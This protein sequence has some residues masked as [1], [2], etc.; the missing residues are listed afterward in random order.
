MIREQKAAPALVLDA[1]QEGI[2]VDRVF[3]R[4]GRRDLW[5]FFP[6]LADEGPILVSSQPLH[7]FH[8]RAP[9]FF[10]TKAS[11]R[12]SQAKLAFDRLVGGFGCGFGCVT[13][14]YVECLRGATTILSRMMS[15]M[16]SACL[17]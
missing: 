6:T 11:K 14:W 10:P 2:R 16:A 3:P 7:H 4:G 5:R 13:V 12:A 9:R 8:A 1:C 17:G 15:M